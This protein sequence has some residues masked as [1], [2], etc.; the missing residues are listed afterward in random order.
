SDPHGARP[1][2]AHDLEPFVEELRPHARIEVL[3]EL[4]ELA[5]VPA[6]ADAEHDAPAVELLEGRNL[7]RNDLRA[8]PRERCYR[9]PERQTV[10]LGGDRGE[11]DPRIGRLRAPHEREV[12]PEEEAVPVRFLR[13]TR[14]LGCKLRIGPAAEIRRGDAELQRPLNLGSRF[15][16]NAARPSFASSDEKSSPNDSASASRFAPWSPPS[17]RFA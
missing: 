11:R 14:C 7:L 5:L 1:Q 9:G 2:T 17:A 10:G 16:T 6:E 15:S 4:R 13:S 12:I 3:A 8:P